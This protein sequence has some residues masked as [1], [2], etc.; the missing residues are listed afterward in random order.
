[1]VEW[2]A[3]KL[4]FYKP[5]RR[6]S[7]ALPDDK[8][9]GDGRNGYD[10]KRVVRRG[11][12]IREPAELIVT[13]GEP[14]LRPIPGTKLS[15]VTNTESVLF[16]HSET[17]KFYFL[18]AGR[19]F[20]ADK[21]GGP[22]V[23][24]SKSLPPDFAAIP[25]GDESEFVKA[26]V[27]G[28]EEAR[29]A[30]LLASV[31]NTT[32][33]RL[34]E[35]PVVVAYD[36][37]PK[38]VAIEGIAV[39][40]AVNTPY[41][42]FQVKTK[43]YCCE[44]GVW[45]V[46]SDAKGPWAF[47]TSVPAEIYAIPPSSPYY[48][49]TYVVVQSSTPTT[50]TYCQTSGYSGEYVATTGVLVFGAGMAVGAAMASDHYY[51]YP[52]Y[53]CYYSYGC[54]ATYH[55]GY[56]GYYAAG[57]A[58]YGPYGGAGY[59]T[60]YNPTTGTYA[61]SAYA[62]GPY[63]SASRTA[64]YNPY[65]GAHAVSTQA[66]TAYGSAGR[67]AAYNPSTGVYAQGR[68]ASGQYGTA[69]S[70]KTNQ[71]TGAAAWSTQNSQ[72]AVAKTKSGDVYATDGD[73]VYKK[74]SSG[75]WSSNSGNGWESASKPQPAKPGAS[76]ASASTQSLQSQAQARQRGNQQTQ[77]VSQYQS[78]AAGRTSGGSRSGTTGGR[79]RR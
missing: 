29:D 55:C 63:G 5:W 16:R 60:A 14:E 25:D 61:R 79:G 11:G 38:F 72:G 53:P 28:T 52:P 74:D 56:G 13:D 73:T 77:K 3:K 33:V 15:R 47:A 22:W 21:L 26:S 34:D 20:A 40:C 19:W 37:P 7:G 57:Y 64:A 48:N 36:G 32:V 12:D 50:V 65:T 39:Q 23:A 41:K 76:T 2:V 70:V 42:V 9:P 49:V 30:V 66:S 44:Q 68:Y 27:P 75:N 8:K 46:A 35:K 6:L 17:R 10:A 45:F 54:A 24:A 69:G 78:S 18:V 58:C 4:E 59:A 62:Y 51:Y 1:M 67:S 71:G 31:P 43:Y